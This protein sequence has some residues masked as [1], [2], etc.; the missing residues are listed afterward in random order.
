MGSA[1]R[2]PRS[3]MVLADGS[4][5]PA[6]GPGCRSDDER[7]GP[8]RGMLGRHV[9]AGGDDGK[10]QIAGAAQATA[11]GRVSGC[12]SRAH[13]PGCPQVAPRGPQRAG[14]DEDDVGAGAQQPHDEP[15]GRVMAADRRS[16]GR[17]LRAEGG[18]SVHGCDEV[19]VHARLGEAEIAAVGGGERPRQ[20]PARQSRLL[21]EQGKSR[22]PAGE[23]GG[24]VCCHAWS[25]GSAAEPEELSPQPRVPVVVAAPV[26]GAGGGLDLPDAAH[27]RAQVHRL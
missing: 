9:A 26:A 4:R 16:G 6:A 20:L 21:V 2:S 24:A 5:P 23:A 10:L 17:V 3:R 14:P 13:V 25:G 27:L 1:D 15:V 11:E 19:G 8:R 7:A 22:P 18:H 12:R